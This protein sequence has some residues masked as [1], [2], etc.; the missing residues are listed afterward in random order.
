M[1]EITSIALKGLVRNTPDGSS[2]DGSLQEAIN[3]RYR[4]G[5]TRGV[6][7]KVEGDYVETINEHQ[8]SY[9][10]PVLP[11]GFYLNY[12]PDTRR[13]WLREANF[14]AGTGD[15]DVNILTLSEGEDF[16]GFAHLNKFLMVYS[17]LNSYTFFWKDT[18]YI[19]LGKL[20]IP[21]FQPTDTDRTAIV[22]EV[23]TESEIINSLQ[24]CQGEAIR[25]IADKQ[26]SNLWNGNV[27][28]R[29]AWKLYDGSYIMHS[30]PYYWNNGYFPSYNDGY[31]TKYRPNIRINTPGTTELLEYYVAKLNLYFHF[32]PDQLA[33]LHD[34]YDAGLID[35][36][37][38]F[39]TRPVPTFDITS[40]P[41]FWV[42][43][44]SYYYY[45]SA[46]SQA[47]KL[48]DITDYYK[49]HEFSYNSIVTTPVGSV[50]PDL[51]GIDLITTNTPLVV[52]DF[53][54]HKLVPSNTLTYNSRM[55]LSNIMVK[56]SDIGDNFIYT[57]WWN[58]GTDSYDDIISDSIRT[59]I[60]GSSLYSPC[61]PEADPGFTLLQV[62]TL[63]T[64]DG[65]KEVISEV[66]KTRRVPG[67]T[68]YGYQL[69]NYGLLLRAYIKPFGAYQDYRC[70]RI[71]FYMRDDFSG[72]HTLLKE[73][74]STGYTGTNMSVLQTFYTP[75]L[76][77]VNTLIYLSTAVDVAAGTPVGLPT[78]NRYIHDTN[79]IQV[80]EQNNP[81]YF[82]AK[83][84]YRI[85]NPEDV[86]IACASINEA[87]SEGQY[88]RFPLY[89]FTSSGMF[90]MEQ[91]D[92]V[93]LYAAVNRLNNEVLVKKYSWLSMDMSIVYATKQGLKVI[94]GRESQEISVPVEGPITNPLLGKPL[95]NLAISDDRLPDMIPKLSRSGFLDT[96]KD[97]VLAYDKENRELIVS[98]VETTWIPQLRTSYTYNFNTNTWATREGVIVG[99]MIKD[100][101]M[102]GIIRSNTIKP[103]GYG[104][105]Y[106]WRALFSREV[107]YG[108]LYNLYAAYSD[109]SNVTNLS[110]SD[111][112][113]IP[114]IEEG[115]DVRTIAIILGGESV[116]GGKMKAVGT[117]YWT[118]PNTGAS[119][120]TGLDVRGCGMRD[121]NG[122]FNGL[123]LASQFHGFP[124]GGSW[125][126]YYDSAILFVQVEEH[127]GRD[128]LPVRFVKLHG[129]TDPGYA[130]GTYT[131]NDGRVYPTVVIGDAVHGYFEYMA[132]NLAETLYRDL[133]EIPIVDAN[134]DWSG[135]STGAMCAYNND[136][137]NVFES[138]PSTIVRDDDNEG[139]R[140]PTIA[141]INYLSLYIGSGNGLNLKLE[142][143]TQWQSANGTN[144]T[145]FGA[146]GSGIRSYLT[147][148]YED[149]NLQLKI[150]LQ[151]VQAD[152]VRA[153]YFSVADDGAL[154]LGADPFN[155]G[156]SVRFVRNATA[157]EL[158]LNDG[159]VP[160][161]Y[162]DN[163]ERSYELMKIGS[164][165]WMAENL[166]D[167]MLQ[168]EL[169]PEVT[170][171]SE[172]IALTSGAWCAYN[173][174][175]NNIGEENRASFRST[176]I[177][178]DEE[179]FP[180]GKKSWVLLQTRPFNL[181]NSS[182]KHINRLIS[183]LNVVTKDQQYSSQLLAGSNDLINWSI[184]SSVQYT[185]EIVNMRNFNPP[186]N[187]NYF[188]LMIAAEREGFSMSQIDV[189]W[190]PRFV[191]KLR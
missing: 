23:P 140:V 127:N 101:E 62:A 178:L 32:K 179:E 191:N 82:P 69:Y 21:I 97:C 172:W 125:D 109:N 3:V 141:D 59:I 171:A 161:I 27:I 155:A 66:P 162:L 120:L 186:G 96:V 166:A 150:W 184:I 47:L 39:M 51:T 11:D 77:S 175:H 79:R 60:F 114:R 76:A 84:S 147:G 6:G 14:E 56:L 126:L 174:D 81:L 43:A 93:V 99:T 65:T 102:K 4:D 45:P 9:N 48:L 90:T 20:P 121:N 22:V 115:Y 189:D 85:G 187:Y 129:L 157:S 2:E 180:E 165:V 105:L 42:M 152:Q 34:Y 151:D 58:P 177:E 160:G 146:V 80:T 112:W 50:I 33:I 173:N 153:Y 168:G 10:H 28:I 54:N 163:N 41:N 16:V 103:L 119:N 38:V 158:L 106:N 53:T 169:L 95:Y 130:Y 113:V 74:K 133:S 30:T 128:G 87:I 46:H 17:D 35:S 18:A 181:S 55:H 12:E 100:G 134:V 31:V 5:A 176:F 116:T 111:D 36:L 170:D 123:K 131:G 132:C 124:T 122:V 182:S 167:P 89:I 70:T 88:G 137:N 8:G 154:T 1:G 149:L 78:E 104:N 25:Q 75:L 67:T 143:D 110:S 61:F 15:H 83:N 24:N 73:I 107:K 156:A 71:R 19:E 57:D 159:H 68:N 72:V 49:I 44:N 108:Y 148:A 142:G 188:I 145:G 135:L 7:D 52:D 37:C 139:W 138:I 190:K 92:G 183:R 136:I 13:I 86:I 63:Y 118:S 64:P 29:L 26:K 91:G 144:S 94:S 185:G 117:K 164:Q 98:K 40:D